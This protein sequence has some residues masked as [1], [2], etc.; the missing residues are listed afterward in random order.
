MLYV[1]F[2]VYVFLFMHICSLMIFN[3]ENKPVKILLCVLFKMLN[4]ILKG[5]CNLSIDNQTIFRRK[6]VIR[7]HCGRGLC[8]VFPGA[9]YLM[10]YLGVIQVFTV[11]KIIAQQIQ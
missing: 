8:Y 3:S 4:I 11:S 1:I 10:L 9:N 2:Y 5:F 6:C 7:Y